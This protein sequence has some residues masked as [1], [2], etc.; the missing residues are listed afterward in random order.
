MWD[1]FLI[2]EVFKARTEFSQLFTRESSEELAFDDQE[3]DGEERYFDLDDEGNPKREE[4]AAIMPT[5]VAHGYTLKYKTKSYSQGRELSHIW[6]LLPHVSF[7]SNVCKQSPISYSGD[8]LS[9]FTLIRLLDRFV[10]RNPKKLKKQHPLSKSKRV[11]NDTPFSLLADG[12][13]DSVPKDEVFIYKY[14][15]KKAAEKREKEG[16]DDESWEND[17]VTSEEFDRYLDKLADFD[18]EH[19]KDD[20]GI[21]FANHVDSK[22]VFSK[23]KRSQKKKTKIAMKNWKAMM[24][25]DP[26]E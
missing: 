10:F 5:G 7:A 14:L 20:V 22:K 19:D 15:K 13:G 8:P 21:D 3:D 9:D 24:R 23:V 6:E 18:G 25:M 11:E 4:A 26:S 17:S 1:S 12:G 16:K 2:S